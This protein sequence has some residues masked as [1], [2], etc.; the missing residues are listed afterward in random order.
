[1]TILY[2]NLQDSVYHEN[3][4]KFWHVISSFSDNLVGRSATEIHTSICI[5]NI[6][7]LSTTLFIETHA[8]ENPIVAQLKNKKAQEIEQSSTL[9]SSL[10]SQ[11]IYLNDDQNISNNNNNNNNNIYMNSSFLSSPFSLETIPSSPLSPL[12][13]PPLPSPSLMSPESKTSFDM[14]ESIEFNDANMTFQQNRDEKENNNSLKPNLFTFSI[15]SSNFLDKKQKRSSL[16]D[17]LLLD[18]T[19]FSRSPYFKL[20]ENMMPILPISLTY[21]SNLTYRQTIGTTTPNA[22]HSMLPLNNP[23]NIET[24]RFNHRSFYDTES[25][26]TSSSCPSVGTVTLRHPLNHTDD[27]SASSPQ[28]QIQY[29]TQL[30][31]KTQQKQINDYYLR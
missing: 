15:S 18:N 1:M 5:F 11:H 2:V 17:P 16:Q 10:C 30:T 28:N 12:T 23:I 25:A 19:D 14:G 31:P 29:F 4:R 21:K 26:R 27:S 9:K 24:S 6:H 20:N 22:T 13:P 3:F 7:K 8:S